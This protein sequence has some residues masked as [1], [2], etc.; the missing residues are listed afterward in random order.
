MKKL[1]GPHQITFDITNKC[2]L[3][4]LYH[5]IVEE[6]LQSQNELSDLEALNFIDEFVD[7][8]LLIFCFVW[9]PFVFRKI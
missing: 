8:K 9:E 1:A 7:V 6:N 2:N 5:I 3:V 4:C